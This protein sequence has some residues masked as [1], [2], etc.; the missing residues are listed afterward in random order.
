MADWVTV[1]QRAHGVVVVLA[2]SI[3]GAE[4]VTSECYSRG[5]LLWDILPLKSSMVTML[6]TVTSV[7]MVLVPLNKSN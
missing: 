6:S 2:T 7:E 4:Y 5:D 1:S 3:S